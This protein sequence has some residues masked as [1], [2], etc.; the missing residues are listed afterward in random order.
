MDDMDIITNVTVH[1]Y[2]NDNWNLEYMEII[3]TYTGVK[4][5]LDFPNIRSNG[6]KVANTIITSGK[7]NNGNKI[8]TTYA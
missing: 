1:K 3:Q 2:G 5:R 4:Y 7:F 8:I 6:D